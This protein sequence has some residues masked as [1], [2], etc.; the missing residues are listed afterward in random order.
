MEIVAKDAR[1]QEILPELARDVALVAQAADDRTVRALHRSQQGYQGWLQIERRARAA[2]LRCLGQAA[3]APNGPTNLDLPAREVNVLPLQRLELRRAQVA[4]HR[5][6]VPTTASTWDA[7]TGHKLRE[8]RR[9]QVDF[10][11]RDA[12]IGSTNVLRWVV[13]PD[14]EMQHLRALRI[15]EHPMERAPDVHRALP[16]EFAAGDLVVQT[17]DN[18]L[19]VGGR[20]VGHPAV[21]Q[22]RRMCVRM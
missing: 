9:E 10:L 13:A 6:R 7:R 20:D 12:A 2:R 19:D 11:C 17:L 4:V 14:A 16:P 8:L 22:C 3:L 5:D 21:T 15:V 18:A 1:G